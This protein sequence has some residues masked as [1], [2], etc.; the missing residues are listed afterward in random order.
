MPTYD[1]KCSKCGHKFE[2][3]DRISAP[4]LRQCPVC[5]Q[6]TAYRLIGAGI[7]LIFKGSGF[8]IT[9]YRKKEYAEGKKKEQKTDDNLQKAKKS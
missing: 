8:Y 7:G 9:D 3:F 5:N 6:K 4:P 2:V 1:Y